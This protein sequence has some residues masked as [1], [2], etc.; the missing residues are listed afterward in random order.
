M[1]RCQFVRLCLLI[2]PASIFLSGC[3]FRS[4]EE[5]FNDLPKPDPAAV[6]GS[7]SMVNLV[8]YNEGDTVSIFGSSVF[9]FSLSG[10]VGVIESAKVFLDGELVSTTNT[11]LFIITLGDLK[12]GIFPLVLQV[13]AGSGTGSLA[14]RVGS[15]KVTITL[16]WIARIDV[17]LPPQPVPN[18]DIVD[19]FLTLQWSAYSKPNF[20]SYLVKRKFPN[21][22]TQTFE[23][24]DKNVTSWRDEMYVGGSTSATTYTVSIVIRKRKRQTSGSRITINIRTTGIHRLALRKNLIPHLSKNT[25]KN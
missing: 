3:V 8:D 7:I 17:S 13:V 10:Q 24:K 9:N 11:G 21:A 19:G 22:S 2:L 14:E 16:K 15:E 20:K 1:I 23:I 25:G 5:Y 18:V 4:D 12:Q 6:S